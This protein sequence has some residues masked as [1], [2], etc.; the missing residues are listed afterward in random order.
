MF[1]FYKFI[2][3]P[4]MNYFVSFSIEI[5]ST[6]SSLFGSSKDEEKKDE[7]ADA[8][9]KKQVIVLFSSIIYCFLRCEIVGLAISCSV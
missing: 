2:S 6:L 4:L 8:G 1:V 9:E 7:K 3:W 5:G